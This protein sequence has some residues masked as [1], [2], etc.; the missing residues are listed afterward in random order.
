MSSVKKTTSE[1]DVQSPI[2][3]HRVMLQALCGISI[4]KFQWKK[5]KWFG[6]RPS[7]RHTV[8]WRN[9]SK[10]C[11]LKKSKRSFSTKMKIFS[12]IKKNLILNPQISPGGQ[13]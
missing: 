3:N 5:E 4:D 6:Q 1:R 8:K 2:L 9:L 11:P 13:K 7:D 10:K 12:K